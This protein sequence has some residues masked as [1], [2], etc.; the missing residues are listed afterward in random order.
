MAKNTLFLSLLKLRFLNLFHKKIFK[1]NK[2]LDCQNKEIWHGK[3][4]NWEDALSFSS[5]YQESTILEK[6]FESLLKVK[7]GEAVYERD[8]V[9]FEKKEYS[10]GLLSSLFYVALSSFG[11]VSVLDFGGSFG[12]SYFQN[13]EFLTLFNQCKWGVV[14]Q[15]QFFNKGK[16]NFKDETLDFYL[17]I[18]ECIKGISPNVFFASGSIQYIKDPLNLLMKINDSNIK[19]LIF[20]RISFSESDCFIT[21]QN[22]PT[23]IYD[24][25]YPCWILNYNWFI[26]TLSN[27]NVVFEFPSFCDPDYVINNNVLVKWRGIMLELK[28]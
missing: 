14:E 4:T 3:Y 7:N 9:L 5:G 1:I 12:T 19:F 25:S 15:S 28:K 13:K 23:E 20:D 11:K 21:I 24:A 26:E 6:C 10:I 17:T 22:V 18:D 16:T 2:N 8:S 27:Y